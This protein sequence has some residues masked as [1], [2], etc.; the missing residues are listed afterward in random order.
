MSDSEK[1]AFDKRVRRTINGRR[2]VFFAVT[3]PGLENLCLEELENL[4]CGISDFS[5]IPGGVE[6]ESDL[7]GLYTASLHLRTATRILMR[8]AEFSASSFAELEKKIIA[9]N[10]EIY[11]PQ[12]CKPEISVKCTKCRLYHSDAISV[13][14]SGWIASKTA[15]VDRSTIRQQ[16][17]IRGMNDRFVV[18]IN[19]SGEPLY[20]RGIKTGFGKAPIRETLA[21][22]MLFWSFIENSR[23]SE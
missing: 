17:F 7:K 2:H 3:A 9:I 18:S 23:N 15:G 14:V 19:A 13:R 6:F 5:V 1:T 16:V 11:L 12:G 22:A 8:V 4:G 21:S 20:K 10:W